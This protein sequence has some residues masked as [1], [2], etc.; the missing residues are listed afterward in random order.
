MGTQCRLTRCCF[1]ERRVVSTLG[2]ALGFAAAQHTARDWGLGC[3]SAF[4]CVHAQR[5]PPGVCIH[6]LLYGGWLLVFDAKLYWF[7]AARHTVLVPAAATGNRPCLV[8]HG[9]GVVSRK[10]MLWCALHAHVLLV[11]G[12]AMLNVSL[13]LRVLDR[14]GCWDRAPLSRNQV[15]AHVFSIKLSGFKVITAGSAMPRGMMTIFT[16]YDC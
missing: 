4:G 8:W 13:S 14:S 10:H 9:M 16:G 12:L 15:L 11:K 3:C 7:T 6:A 1:V 5:T 2:L